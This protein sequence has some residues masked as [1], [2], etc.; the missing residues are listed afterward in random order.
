MIYRYLTPDKKIK[1]F[2][3]L[4]NLTNR[5]TDDKIIWF[6]MGIF[7]LTEPSYSHSV[8]N[9]T[10]SINAQDKMSMLNGTLGGRLQ[11]PVSFAEKKNGKLHSL[12]WREIFLTAAVNMGNEDPARVIIDSVPDYINEYTQVKNVSGL[13]D[14]FIHVNAPAD[15]EGERIIVKAWSPNTPETEINFSKGDRVYKLRRFGPPDPSVGTI[16][17]QESYQKNLNE[18]V[19]AIFEDIVEAL[20]NTHEFFY[21]R[22]GDLMFQP[23]KNYVNESFDPDKDS[24]LGYFAYE[25][26]MDDFIPNYLGLPFTYNFAN[27]KTI[28]RY[29]NNPS[30]TNIKNDFIVSRETGE[31]LEIAIDHKPTIREIR[32]WFIGVAEDFN[33]D[34]IEMDFLAKDGKR[35]EPYN[36]QT[37]TVPFEFKEATAG[38]P[39]QYIDI[40][41]DKIPWQ[42][43]L[44]LKNYFVRNIYGA[45]TVRVLPRWGKECES[46]I[47]KWVASEDKKTL[48]PNTGIFN[49]SFIAVGTPWLAG[50]PMAASANTENDVES[51]DKQNPIF[52]DKGDS[53]YWTYFLDIIPTESRL[54]QYSIELIGKRSIGLSNKQA[55]TMFRTSPNEL[56]VVTETELQDL[57][58]EEILNDLKKQGDAYAV[59]RDIQ[60]QLFTPTAIN[61]NKDIMPYSAMIGNPGRF[62]QL[63]FMVAETNGN[64]H[65]YLIGGKH[66][67]TIGINKNLQDQERDGYVSIS[68]GVYTDPVTKKQFTQTDFAIIKTPFGDEKD[69]T[70]YG[71]LAFI[72]N[73]NSRCPNSGGHNYFAVVKNIG[74]TWYYAKEKGESAEWVKFDWDVKNDFLVGVLTKT[75]YEGNSD[76]PSW[77]IGRIESFE[78]LFNIR[79]S[80]MENL[81]SIDGAVDL[82]TSAKGLIYQHTNTSDVVT[83]D[84]LPVYHLEPNTLI[85]AEDE[86]TNIS[87]MFMITGYSLQLNTEGSPTMSIS[88]IQTNPAI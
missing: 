30:Y 50:Y 24:D 36:A 29:N 2:I 60:D 53:A 27:K 70:P 71:F 14:K 55:S 49:P 56:I 37:N 64:T 18:P 42:I 84:T 58:G 3:G 85:Y 43:A 57:G 13:K 83:I 26:T 40:P 20:S 54:G 16:S 1:L 44:G 65:E 77:S 47:F 33:L 9:S 28:I 63:K 62:E 45:S 31:I 15:L 4:E 46:M 79:E 8:D 6:N 7:I 81:F 19:T 48:L 68:A 10:I 22:E 17:T 51:L 82:F 75:I 61:K 35:R 66:T 73:K 80:Q 11:A 88:A 25:L 5:F 67:G 87:G 39:T 52:T 32:E 78:E 86:I 38:K 74:A 59:I 76:M 41:L 69:L 21:T 23:I 12:S 72:L 34:S